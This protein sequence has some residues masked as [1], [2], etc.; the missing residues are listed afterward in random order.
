MADLLFDLFGFSCFAYV[1]LDTDL[2]VLANPDQSNRRSAVQLW[3]FPYEVS[4]CSLG[5]VSPLLQLA[6]L[7]LDWFGLYQTKS[8]CYLFVCSKASDYKPVKL[9]TSCNY[10]DTSPYTVSVLSL[11]TS[12]RALL[13]VG[14]S[15]PVFIY[16]RLFNAVDNNKVNKC[17]I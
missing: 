16:F 17:S 15:R 6:G 12:K 13:K 4:E 9:E 7:Q 5:E 14:H 8:F 2:Q 1:E 3:Y 11:C 10:G